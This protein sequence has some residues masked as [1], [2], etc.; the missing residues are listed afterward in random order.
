M[1]LSRVPRLPRW[2]ALVLPLFLVGLT[3]GLLFHVQ[4]LLT[5]EE[6]GHYVRP[7]GIGFVV[8]IALVTLLGGGR[9]GLLTL[10]LSVLASMYFLMAPHFSFLVQSPRDYAE[11][12][13][14]SFV[15]LLAV[16]GMD[17]MRKNAEMLTQMQAATAAMQAATELQRA[18]LKD[19]L[20]SVTDKK[21]HLCDSAAELPVCLALAGEPL[22]VT[23]QSLRLLRQRA[24]EVA[25][26]QGFA[27]ERC[28]DLITAVGEA[29]MNAV[30]H[31]GG[32]EARVCVG[33]GSE[34]TV[35]VWVEDKGKGITLESLPQ[36]TLE[37]GHSTVGTL[38]HGFWLM[39]QTADRSRGGE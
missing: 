38:G 31:A 12:V 11:L 25:R 19:V 14:L 7:F 9:A 32:G 6:R 29:A 2:T 39:L 28:H 26:S 27:D 21:L 22:P 20:L 33:P 3:T 34:K 23:E 36:A 1:L 13:F 35:Q 16:F 24:R 8:P 17:A 18:F 15:G 30:V 37:R 4:D 10:L 5:Q